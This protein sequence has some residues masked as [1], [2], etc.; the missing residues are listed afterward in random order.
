MWLVMQIGMSFVMCVLNTHLC[1]CLLSLAG[2]R[3]WRHGAAAALPLSGCHVWSHS[4]TKPFHL[5]SLGPTTRLVSASAAHGP[6]L[7]GSALGPPTCAQLTEDSPHTGGCP[8]RGTPHLRRQLGRGP[9][10][11]VL[12]YPSPRPQG[13]N[14]SI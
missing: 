2:G 3:T 8:H 10:R 9:R 12:L 11:E 13:C 4:L 6:G 1:V 14:I 5:F 7:P